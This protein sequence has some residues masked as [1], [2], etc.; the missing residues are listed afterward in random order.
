MSR[1]EETRVVLLGTGVV[2]GA[3]LGILD[4][5]APDTVALHGVVNRRG[6]L[7]GDELSRRVDGSLTE[8]ARASLAELVARPRS[9]SAATTDLPEGWLE[10]LA[11]PPETVLVDATAA[12]GMERLYER[13]LR[14]GLH[15]VSANK[16][17]FVCRHEA[18]ARLFAAAR[19]AARLRYSATVGAGL[20][21]I[22]T[23]KDL[24]RTGDRVRRIDCVLSGTLGFVCQ[25]LHRGTPL[26]RAVEIARELGFTEPDP[27]EDLAGADVARKA[28]ILARELGSAL[29]VDE[30][31]RE[32]FVPRAALD[33]PLERLGAELRALDV[34]LGR[35]VERLAARGER[36][37]YLARVEVVG[38]EVR[39]TAGPTAVPTDHP[40]ASLTGPQA[41]VAFQTERH[42]DAPLVVSGS[43]AGGAVTAAALLADVLKVAGRA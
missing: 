2:G 26:S 29:E 28:V 30:V 1:D 6:Y 34:D 3:L 10:A 39:A 8:H 18:R 25:E 33:A 17:P 7:L 27:R 20:P 24:V 42:R 36:L 16:K 11:P 35:R 38:G 13:A 21:V 37:V 4:G 31:A 12:A 15:V 9:S 19:G 23:L 5:R 43:G 41:L 22:E 32:P 40:A 14:A